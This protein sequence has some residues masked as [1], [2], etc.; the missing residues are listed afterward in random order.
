MS[1]LRNKVQLIGNLGNDPEIVNLESGK[2]LA[3]FSIATNETYKNT[4]GERVTDTQ[5]HNVV[6]WGK[7]AEIIE[8]YATKGKEVAIEGKLTSRSYETKQGEKRYITEI[9]CDELLLLSK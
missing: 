7:T 8:N 5:W 6:A 2:K 1:T 4:K 9:V 3:K